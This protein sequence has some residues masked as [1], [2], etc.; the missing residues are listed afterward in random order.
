MSSGSDDDG[1]QGNITEVAEAAKRLR[2]TPEARMH[3]ANARN[4]IA[5][6]QY[7]D[8]VEAGRLASEAAPEYHVARAVYGYAAYKDLQSLLATRQLRKACELAQ[9]QDPDGEQHGFDSESDAS[10][11][12]SS[13]NSDSDCSSASDHGKAAEDTPVPGSPAARAAKF[14]ANMASWVKTETALSTYRH[15]YALAQ[16]QLRKDP[17]SFMETK[18]EGPVKNALRSCLDHTHP[19]GLD[20]DISKG[21]V[22]CEEAID[23]MLAAAANIQVTT[24]NMDSNELGDEG[25]HFLAE[26]LA[27]D[28]HLRTVNLRHNQI[29]PDG[30]RALCTGALCNARLEK[31]KEVI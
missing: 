17:R 2:F 11:T 9:E 28:I 12:E 22:G 18:P 10:E 16:E 8:A 31:A 29:T 21:H 13:S 5:S 19:N 25:A 30:I 3:A 15:I 26:Q 1:D 4:L 6:G 27:V 24:L 7:N 20:I 14:Q 23:V